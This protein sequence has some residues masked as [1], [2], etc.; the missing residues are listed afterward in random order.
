MALNCLYHSLHRTL[1]VF[2]NL[3]PLNRTTVCERLV[4]L[5]ICCQY[6]DNIKA[7]KTEYQKLLSS[8]FEVKDISQLTSQQQC[9]RGGIKSKSVGF[10][11]PLCKLAIETCCL[12]CSCLSSGSSSAHSF[13][14]ALATMCHP[15]QHSDTLS[16]HL[17]PVA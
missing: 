3:K 9:Y 16:V 12:Y 6:I 5:L 1:Q 17:L 2:Y 4:F 13:F 10:L 15:E 7:C 14:P 11:S 8:S